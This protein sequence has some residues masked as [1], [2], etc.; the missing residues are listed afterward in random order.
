MSCV[1]WLNEGADLAANGDG[2]SGGAGIDDGPF[3]VAETVDRPLLVGGHDDA[4]ES[5]SS[6][7]FVSPLMPL[8]DLSSLLFMELREAHEWF[9]L[10]VGLES[11]SSDWRESSMSDD[12]PFPFTLALKCSAV[13]RNDA[14]TS[15]EWFN[16]SP[17][18]M[19]PRDGE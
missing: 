19:L 7:P 6:F 15:D 4:D 8:D 14:N 17:P 11:E 2:G 12:L 18:F 3:P 13:F 1:K 5:W 16:G 9:P 10:L